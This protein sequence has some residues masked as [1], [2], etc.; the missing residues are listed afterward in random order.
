MTNILSFN[1]LK[2]V[3]MEVLKE[4]F[5]L[6]GLQYILLKRNERVALYGIG[7]TYT[8]EPKHFEVCKIYIRKDDRYGRLRE[9]VPNNEQFGRDLSR[10]FNDYESALKYF[11]ELT[12]RYNLLQGVPEA[13][14]GVQ[15]NVPEVCG[16]QLVEV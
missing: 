3:E 11:D 16:L 9:S 4:R 7:G 5:R 6:N 10:C 2:T 12:T 13:V 8:D 14:T 1:T 15:T